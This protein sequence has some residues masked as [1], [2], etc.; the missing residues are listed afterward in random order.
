MPDVDFYLPRLAKLQFSAIQMLRGKER[1]LEDYTD[2]F[3]L[4]VPGLMALGEDGLLKRYPSIVLPQ[5]QIAINLG[6]EAEWR[7]PN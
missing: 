6:F 2:C 3:Q 4:D 7:W 1:L 5:A